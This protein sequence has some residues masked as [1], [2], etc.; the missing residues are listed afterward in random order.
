MVYQRYTTA[1][2][3]SYRDRADAPAQHARAVGY[4]EWLE[5]L[6]IDA[7]VRAELVEQARALEHGF[8]QAERAHRH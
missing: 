7:T 2:T 3:L 5:Q 6:A 8:E 1:V 4:R